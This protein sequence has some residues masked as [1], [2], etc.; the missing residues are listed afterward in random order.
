VVATHAQFLQDRGHIVTITALGR[1]KP[2]MSE[3]LR[4][5]KKGRIAPEKP[6]DDY[7]F[8][9]IGVTINILDYKNKVT[10]QD[11]PDADVVIATLW[12]T[13]EWVDALPPE[14]G[15]KVYFIQGHEV[16][17]YFPADRVRATY[18]LPMHQITVSNWL[19]Q[20][21]QKEYGRDAPALVP[22]S[23][24]FEVFNSPPREKRDHPRIGFLYAH[25]SVKGVDVTTKAIARI[26]KSMPEIEVISFGSVEPSRELPLPMNCE[27]HHRPPQNTIRDIYTSCDAWITGSRL[28][29]FG[30][31]ILEAAA[32]RCP[33]VSTRAGGPD[34][35][36]DNGETG[37]LV[38]LE[39]D[40]AL[41]ARTIDILS[42]KPD[43]WR[44]MST[45]AYERAR[46]YTWA[47]AGKKFETTLY[48][49]LTE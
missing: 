28:E 44:R 18:H 46:I 11:L 48:D 41:A 23:V 27:F 45:N 40:Q 42:M 25:S 31:T 1:Q 4:A 26:Q 33:N 21:M 47:D 34:D 13:A 6:F 35:L 24:N 37:Y 43:D 30:L 36:I 7:H 49:A 12:R 19:G 32:C 2:S 5:L 20:L 38:E 3:R 8:K 14:K 10:A 22:N 39:N 9:D 29:G 16:F 15:N 17:P